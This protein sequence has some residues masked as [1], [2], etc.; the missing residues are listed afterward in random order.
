MTKA[1]RLYETQP[2]PFE[3]QAIAWDGANYDPSLRQELTSQSPA[4]YQWSA[5]G[6][7]NMLAT[8]RTRTLT[9]LGE[10]LIVNGASELFVALVDNSASMDET[11]A[12]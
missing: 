7:D 1:D 8:P 3:W 4:I 6:P 12:Q 10:D 5:I 9:I 11:Y 2:V